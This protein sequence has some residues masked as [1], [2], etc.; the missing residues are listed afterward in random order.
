MN[1][2][3]KLQANYSDS[4]LLFYGLFGLLCGC[5]VMGKLLTEL[6][7]GTLYL[8]G[9]SGPQIIAWVDHPVRFLIYS[10][11]GGLFSVWMIFC[12]VLC[13]AGAI[14]TRVSKKK[15]YES[16]QQIGH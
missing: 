10:A 8:G 3:R 15:L 14:A 2:V 6:P 1:L 4:K 13:L 7:D 16:N 9:R 11:L 5:M 12:G